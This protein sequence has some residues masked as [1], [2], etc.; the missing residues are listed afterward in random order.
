MKCKLNRVFDVLHL[1]DVCVCT[2]LFFFYRLS[3][4][5]SCVY[6]PSICIEGYTKTSAAHFAS[7]K[8][9]SFHFSK[10]EETLS[11]KKIPR[12]IL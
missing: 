11:S 2:I 12:T 6:K 5:F 3:I 9:G 4:L 1:C 10:V 7:I 8:G